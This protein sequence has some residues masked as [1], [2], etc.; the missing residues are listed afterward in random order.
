MIF[1]GEINI[2]IIKYFIAYMDKYLR[3]TPQLLNYRSV[4]S[5]WKIDFQRLH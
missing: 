4:I 2:K 3:N 1:H 5:K